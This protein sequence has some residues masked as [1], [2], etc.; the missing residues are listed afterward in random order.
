MWTRIQRT[1]LLPAR[2]PLVR[3]KMISDPVSRA[4]G[5]E[6]LLIPV[7]RNGRS[8]GSIQYAICRSQ[9]GERVEACLLHVEEPVAQWELP[10]T[11]V[12]PEASLRKQIEYLLSQ[13]TRPL[14]EHG[15]PYA[16]YMRSGDVVFSILDAAE[17]LE[18]Q[19]IVVPLPRPGWRRLFSHDVVVSLYARQR[20]IPVVA[21]ADDGA[22]LR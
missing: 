6:R 19:Q 12:R 21:V 15:I 17:E 14:S 11:A 13:V 2:F 5:T 20:D 16:A 9:A 8:A 18:C 22:P 1:L 7:G 10:E 4:A 3:D